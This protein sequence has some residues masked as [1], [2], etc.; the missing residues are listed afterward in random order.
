MKYTW[1]PFAKSRIKRSTGLN[2]HRF[3]A[4]HKGKKGLWL[5][6]VARAKKA[7]KTREGGKREEGRG[8]NSS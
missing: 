4:A 6:T 3:V 1:I 2:V 5:G 7:G 8:A